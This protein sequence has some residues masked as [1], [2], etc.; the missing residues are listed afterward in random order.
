[1]YKLLYIAFEFLKL[2]FII[3]IFL[4]GSCLFSLRQW[5]IILLLHMH[6]SK[7]EVNFE[8]NRESQLYKVDS[9]HWSL[10]TLLVAY[11]HL[12]HEENFPAFL[13]HVNVDIWSS[14]NLIIS[15]FLLFFVVLWDP[16]ILP[17]SNSFLSWINGG[18]IEKLLRV[19]GEDPKG[20]CYR[21][22]DF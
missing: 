14:R 10:S 21:D 12:S 22:S 3:L 5:S 7:Q 17:C 11:L 18:L 19:P 6:L 15:L 16:W 2:L 8:L 4:S 9:H 13:K 1:M 20:N